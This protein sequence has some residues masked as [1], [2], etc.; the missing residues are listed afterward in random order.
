[1]SKRVAAQLTGNT[2]RLFLRRRHSSNGFIGP[3]EPLISDFSLTFDD[4]DGDMLFS[5][6]ELLTFSGITSPTTMYTWLFRVPDIAGIADGGD[7]AW[8]FQPETGPRELLTP[9]TEFSYAIFQIGTDIPAPGTFALLGAGLLGFGI[10]DKKS[11][12][13]T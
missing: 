3:N 9:V 12:G 2:L 8:G 10:S 13:S 5:L 4:L 7:I 1:M 6:D 11:T